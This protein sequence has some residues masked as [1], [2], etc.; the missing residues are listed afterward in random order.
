MLLDLG[1]GYINPSLTPLDIEFMKCL[2]E[3]VNIIPLIAKA[4]TLTPEECQQFKKQS[5]QYCLGTSGN[6]KPRPH[7]KKTGKGFVTMENTCRAKASASAEGN[8]TAGGRRR[9]RRTSFTRSLDHVSMPTDAKKKR[10]MIFPNFGIFRQGELYW[11]PHFSLIHRA[12]FHANK[13]KKNVTQHPEGRKATSLS[14]SAEAK[15]ACGPPY[16]SFLL[17]TF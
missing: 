10:S 7:M 5:L 9:K 2:H 15:Q 3:K 1:Q 17:L 13:G 6:S 12:L 11:P 4:D 16:A 14:P 8:D